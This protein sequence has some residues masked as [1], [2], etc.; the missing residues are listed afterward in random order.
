[1]LGEKPKSG[2]DAE[3]IISYYINDGVYGSFNCILYDHVDVFPKVLQSEAS[4]PTLASTIWGP[5]CDSMDK[6]VDRVAL[7][8]LALGDWLY[9]EDMGAYTCCASS[10]FNGFER[11]NKHYIYSGACESHLS[12]LPSGFPLSAAPSKSSADL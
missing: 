12:L 10:T 7:P 4:G 5:T 11:P 8:K 3:E 6:V 2:G 1:M 9:F